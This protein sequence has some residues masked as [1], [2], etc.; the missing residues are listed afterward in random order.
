MIDRK[1]LFIPLL[2]VMAAGILIE[3]KYTDP[4]T[5]YAVEPAALIYSIAVV[6][7]CIALLIAAAFI[8]GR[9]KLYAL[10]AAEPSSFILLSGIIAAAAGALR[11]IGHFTGWKRVTV[12]KG[13]EFHFRVML[14]A[15][16]FAIIYAVWTVSA[17]RKGFVG[18][19]T[20]LSVFAA[21]WYVLRVVEYETSGAMNVHRWR[22]HLV[23]IGCL[24][25]FIALARI[26]NI[27]ASEERALGNDSKLMLLASAAA[28]IC[29]SVP[30][31]VTYMATGDAVMAMYALS[32]AAVGIFAAVILTGH[33]GEIEENDEENE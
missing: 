3:L 4:Y 31:A 27:C 6:G 21:G 18:C 19:S 14:I 8:A 12:G 2:V 5:G 22:D 17:K 11:L 30:G 33:I 28:A 20:A 29:G 32:D 10:D 26:L 7:L 9:G 13:Q 1:K 15:A 24:A 23:L 25:A 16:V